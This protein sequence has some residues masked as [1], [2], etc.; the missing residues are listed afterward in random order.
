MTEAFIWD[1]DTPKERRTDSDETNALIKDITYEIEKN[2]KQ[3]VYSH[4]VDFF[5]LLSINHVY[6]EYIFIKYF[7]CTLFFF[8][9]SN[10]LQVYEFSLVLLL[11]NTKIIDIL[12]Y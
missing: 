7:F 2:G 4:E 12:N 3:L 9:T 11:L 5:R 1:K 8:I 10:K 6:T